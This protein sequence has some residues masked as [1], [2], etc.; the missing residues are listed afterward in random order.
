MNTF[1]EIN[2]KEIRTNIKGIK[3]QYIIWKI[4]GKRMIICDKTKRSLNLNAI[5]RT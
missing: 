3:V 4:A 1:N 5:W 2:K